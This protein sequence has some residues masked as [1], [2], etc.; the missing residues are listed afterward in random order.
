MGITEVHQTQEALFIDE[1]DTYL[2]YSTTDAAIWAQEY[3]KVVRQRP[4]L[5]FDEG[6]ILTW[7]ANAIETAKNHAER[8]YGGGGC[9]VEEM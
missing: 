5:A 1:A 4:D 9:I 6:F 8:S 7:F 2:L 3:M